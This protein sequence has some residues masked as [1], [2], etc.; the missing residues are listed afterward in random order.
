MQ[1]KEF[2]WHLESFV[3]LLKKEKDY[4]IK[5][6]GESLTS[7][8]S[9]KESFVKVIE[10][11]QGEISE[12]TRE[13]ITKIKTQQEENLLLT[14]QAIS[15]QTMLMEAIKK[16]LSSPT[17][18]YSKGAQIYAQPRTNFVDEEI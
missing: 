16:N 13:L 6:D 9:K 11:Y 1:I 8:L 7:L 2:E 12:K 10:E 4:L 17:G 14:K 15:Y 18:T 3:K 5:D